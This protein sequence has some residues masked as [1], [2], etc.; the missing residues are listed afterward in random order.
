[1]QNKQICPKTGVIKADVIYK[2]KLMPDKTF[3]PEGWTREKIIEKTVEALQNPIEKPFL[4]D[5]G[6]WLIKGKTSEGVRIDYFVTQ[7]RRNKNF[8]SKI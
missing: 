6:K 8:L 3:Y 1:L 2:G 5:D 4:Q 7:K